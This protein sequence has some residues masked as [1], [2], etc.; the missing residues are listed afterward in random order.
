MS[1]RIAAKDGIDLGLLYFG[2]QSLIEAKVTLPFC[3]VV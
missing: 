3:R 2:H 1:K